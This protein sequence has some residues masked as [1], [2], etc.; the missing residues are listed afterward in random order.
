MPGSECSQ[1]SY[2]LSADTVCTVLLYW[3][4][5]QP[6]K[7]PSHS[8]TKIRMNERGLTIIYTNEFLVMKAWDMDKSLERIAYKVL[9]CMRMAAI[10]H[11]PNSF[12]FRIANHTAAL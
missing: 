12:P 9:G 7:T 5:M 6:F 4:S 11:N 8:A 10:G 1:P 2:K 3:I